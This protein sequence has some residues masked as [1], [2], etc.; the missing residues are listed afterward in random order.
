M[1][2]RAPGLRKANCRLRPEKPWASAEGPGFD[3]RQLHFFRTYPRAAVPGLRP[4]AARSTA[5]RRLT[6]LR[7]ERQP[8]PIIAGA[9]G[10]AGQRT[11]TK[12]PGT[13]TRPM[14]TT[15]G[16]RTG[17]VDSEN[18]PAPYICRFPQSVQPNADPPTTF[19]DSRTRRDRRR[20]RRSRQN[21]ARV[22]TI[23]PARN[24]TSAPHGWAT[25]KDALAGRA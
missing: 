1:S 15:R 6:P 8:S 17:R 18:L 2:A 19:T 5:D 20:P 7:R 11:R 21:D 12:V 14:S 16:Q 10:G 24:A 22:S 25:R 9:S 3:S 4:T 23:A 13:P